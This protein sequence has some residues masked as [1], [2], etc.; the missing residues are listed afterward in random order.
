MGLRSGS[1]RGR[2]KETPEKANA[3]KRLG[4]VRRTQQIT[5][6][7]VGSMVAIGDQS[8]LI[9]SLDS[10]RV[11]GDPEIHEPRL[12]S[13]LRVD[14]FRLPPAANPPSG[15]GVRVRRFP[16]QYSCQGC[17]A[18][19]RYRD[20]NGAKGEGICGSCDRA[21]TPSR[22]ILA[23]SNGHLDEFPYWEWVHRRT[24]PTG[25][26]DGEKHRLK[27]IT[28]GRTA[29]LRSIVIECD[30][31]KKASMEGAF[32]GRAMK[33]LGIT[34]PGGQPWLGTHTKVTGCTEIP[35][36]LQ[37]GSS[38]AWFPT[39]R[40]SLSIPPWHQALMQLVIREKKMLLGE[41]AEWI[42][43]V[44][45]KK[46][47]LDKYSVEEVLRAVRTLDSAAAEL[48]PDPE[49]PPALEASD[50]LREEEYRQLLIGAEETPEN[51]HFVCVPPVS[52]QDDPPL[53]GIDRTMLVKR[54]REVRALQY[55]SRVDTPLPTDPKR[56][57]APLHHGAVNWL[58]AI[59]VIG[60]GVFLRLDP[61]RLAAWEAKTGPD[62]PARRVAHLREQHTAVLKSRGVTGTAAESPVTARLV[63]L[64]TLAH[65]LINEW[66]LDCGYPAASLR[67]RLY[68]SDEMAG[69]LL[70]TASSDSAG[71]LGGVIAQ[72][73]PKK[74]AASLRAALDRV[75]WCSADPLCMESDAGGVDSLNLAACHAC[76]LLPET[77]CEMNNTF[78]DRG[79]LVGTGATPGYFAA[80]TL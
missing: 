34:C 40:S 53:P 33:D 80:P 27:L 28:T 31:G 56:R 12:E 16:T 41:D 14:G 55:F 25:G 71:S 23:C 43:R 74:L 2:G 4:A 48:Q 60:E 47:W 26:R 35:R 29:S 54:L 39:V 32:G 24:D 65:A 21:V 8:F 46:E 77:S 11:R 9:S 78:L 63:L 59:E 61:D 73:T 10:W 15:D 72:G 44:A 76:V 66:S 79:L 1:A 49:T 45:R 64:H 6:Y 62:S 19:K 68:V 22:F 13:R 7:G 20:F 36:A 75:S 51:E 38:A 18:L 5:T 70:Y 50:V 69:M 37:R 3:R 58:P 67:E 52:S 17:G 42:E 57:R 30:C